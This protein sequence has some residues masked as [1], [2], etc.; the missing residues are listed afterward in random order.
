MRL[1]IVIRSRTFKPLS[2]AG[3]PQRSI[4]RR[5]GFRKYSRNAKPQP[6]IGGHRLGEYALYCVSD[7][8]KHL[9]KTNAAFFT[10]ETSGE[11]VSKLR[12]CNFGVHLSSTQSK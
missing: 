4:L 8:S 5:D 2:F 11:L 7:P 12:S 3:T 10:A 6:T 9:Y 1:N